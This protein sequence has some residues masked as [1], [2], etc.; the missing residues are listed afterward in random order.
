MKKSLLAA[1]LLASLTLVACGKKDDAPAAPP[2]PSSSMPTDP[3]STPPATPGS[4]PSGATT[5][6]TAPGGT[7]GTAR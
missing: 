6:P 4:V 2:T 3:A 7:T 1:S 5:T